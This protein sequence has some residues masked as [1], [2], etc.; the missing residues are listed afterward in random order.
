MRLESPVDLM[1]ASAI[2]ILLRQGDLA[3]EGELFQQSP[4]C[5]ISSFLRQKKRNVLV[6]KSRRRFCLCE[7]FT[8][9]AEIVN[10]PAGNFS[11]REFW[12]VL[13]LVLAYVSFQRRKESGYGRDPELP[14]LSLFEK[15]FPA[16]DGSG[17]SNDLHA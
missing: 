13:V 9:P 11:Y 10:V 8:D 16:D 5:S 3:K 12:R 4:Y 7:L 2:D 1:G 15:S 6:I 17:R 14:L